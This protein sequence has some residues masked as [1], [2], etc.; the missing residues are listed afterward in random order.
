MALLNED[1]RGCPQCGQKRSSAEMRSC[2]DCGKEVCES[3]CRTVSNRIL[4]RTCFGKPIHS[5]GGDDVS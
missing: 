3:C 4:C 5:H 2:S 1:Q